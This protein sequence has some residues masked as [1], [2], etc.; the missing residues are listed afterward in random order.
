MARTLPHMPI[1]TERCDF[2]FGHRFPLG[3]RLK[4][5]WRDVL[6][7][8][9]REPI[10]KTAT[11]QPG[12]CPDCIRDCLPCNSDECGR[13]EPHPAQAAIAEAHDV[14]LME[15]RVK[16]GED[17]APMVTLSRREHL[18]LLAIEEASR[19]LLQSRTDIEVNFQTVRKL[20]QGDK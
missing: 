15:I 9:L 19:T 6:C 18:R 3:T 11:I 12:T 20:L 7:C 5:E 10:A 14:P 2:C 8:C 1:G 4:A 13:T 17:G 16:A